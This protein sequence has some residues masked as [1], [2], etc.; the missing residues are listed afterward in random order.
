LRAGAKVEEA[1]ARIR[2]QVAPLDQDRVLT[3][4]IATIEQ[5]IAEG[6]LAGEA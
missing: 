5:L 3:G 4:D 6:A 2:A 1:H